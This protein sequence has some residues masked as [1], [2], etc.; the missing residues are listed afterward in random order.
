MDNWMAGWLDDDDDDDDDDDHCIVMRRG[1]IKSRIP[2]T[3]AFG[4]RSSMRMN[5]SMLLSVTVCT[6]LLLEIGDRP[7]IPWPPSW[8][9]KRPAEDRP[10][11]FLFFI[12]FSSSAGLPSRAGNSVPTDLRSASQAWQ[13]VMWAV[14]IFASKR[15]TLSNCS[16]SP[17]SSCPLVQPQQQNVRNP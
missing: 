9:Y 6:H 5:N 16:L 2:T 4:N 7:K 15:E 3:V 1:N 10:S 12:C 11:I 14:H 8:R 17:S 13:A